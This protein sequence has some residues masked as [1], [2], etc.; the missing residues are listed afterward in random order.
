MDDVVDVTDGALG[1]GVGDAPGGTGIGRCVD[2]DFVAG[3][4]VEVFSPIDCAVRNRGDVQRTCTANDCV[5]TPKFGFAG[6][7]R[8]DR[9]GN[10]GHE[11]ARRQHSERVEAIA[12]QARGEAIHH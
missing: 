5:R 9:S 8:D 2:V 7:E 4:V 3:A 1:E 10:R 12:K 6:T 11:S